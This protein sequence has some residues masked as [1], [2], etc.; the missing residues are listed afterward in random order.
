MFECISVSYQRKYRSLNS[1]IKPVMNSIIIQLNLNHNK[2][3]I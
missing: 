3:K 1:P 2:I